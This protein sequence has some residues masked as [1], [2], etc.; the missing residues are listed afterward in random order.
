V[1]LVLRMLKELGPVASLSRGYGRR[2]TDIHEVKATDTAEISGDEPVQLKRR[3]PAVRVFV[4]AD[5]VEAIARIQRSVPGVLAVVLDDAFQHRRLDAHLNILLTRW[6][7]PWCDDAL[8]PAGGLRD[9]PVRA[10]GAQ[11]VV[12]TKCPGLPSPVEQQVWRRRLGLRTDQ[13][14]C[15]SDI[16]YEPP[17]AGAEELDGNTLREASCLLFTGI[18]DPAP[19]VDHLRGLFARVEHVAFPDHHVFSASELRG[20]AERYANFAAGPKWLVTTEKDAARLA[21][22]DAEGPLQDVPL[23]TIGIRAR[24]LNEP[25]RLEQLVRDLVGAHPTDR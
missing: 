8:V 18:A 21:S 5:R 15:F 25:E 11:V 10:R 4:G 12:L 2:G 13:L 14:L 16:V 23:A 20:L 22:S 19:L 24:I 6:D 3:M 7:R 1:E 17:R 9:L